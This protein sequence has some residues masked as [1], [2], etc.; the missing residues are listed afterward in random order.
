MIPGMNPRD[1]QKMMKRMGIQQQEIP[2]TKVIIKTA[3]KDIIITSPS[4]QKINMMGQVNFQ[5]SGE[6][7]E[8]ERDATPDI[9]EDDLLTVMQ[10]ANVDKDSAKKALEEA[11]G[12]LAKAIMDLQNNE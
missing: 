9:N 4:V 3:E 11:D 2:A 1:M 6:I 5:I 12:D 10:T 7:E 8:K